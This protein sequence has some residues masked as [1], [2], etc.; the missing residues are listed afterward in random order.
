MVL[1]HLLPPQLVPPTHPHEPLS[2]PVL[3]THVPAPSS[4]HNKRCLLLTNPSCP[5]DMEKLLT[6][7]YC[8]GFGFF[9]FPPV[10]KYLHG[11]ASAVAAE[12]RARISNFT[13]VFLYVVTGHPK[14]QRQQLGYG[15]ADPQLFKT[16]LQNC[17]MHNVTTLSVTL[18]ARLL[19]PQL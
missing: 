12:R 3:L 13:S 15:R 11:A 8:C 10:P 5:R 4:P 19:S 2:S 6:L 17:S 9:S 16:W 18:P 14:K 7:C 1:S